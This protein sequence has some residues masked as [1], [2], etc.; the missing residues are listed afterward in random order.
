MVCMLRM[1]RPSRTGNGGCPFTQVR[2]SRERHPCRFYNALQERA[3]AGWLRWE[4]GLEGSQLGG[5]VE[6]ALMLPW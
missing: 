1:L 2:L 6:G 4:W 3:Q 5:E